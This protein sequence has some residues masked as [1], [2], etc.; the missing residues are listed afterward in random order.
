MD[1]RDRFLSMT[2]QAE[3]NLGLARSSFMRVLL[4]VD[5]SHD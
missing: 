2:G 4:K 1:P 5:P 3:N